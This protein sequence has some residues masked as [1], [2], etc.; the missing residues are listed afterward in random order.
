MNEQDPAR[1]PDAPDANAPSDTIDFGYER[2]PIGEKAGRVAEVFRSVAPRYDVM[3]DLMSLG[4]HRIL[5]RMTIEL[6]GV[7]EG[8]RVLDLAGG[9]GDLARLF[10]PRVG[11]RGRVILS[12]INAAMLEVGRDRM[13]DEGHANVDAV[14]ADAE[15]LPFADGTFDCV[16]IAFGLRNVTRKD[17]A[18]EEMRRVLAPGGRL[19]VLEFSKPRNPLLSRAYDAF[20]A[21]WPAMGRLVAGDADSYRYLNESIRMHP[22]QEALAEMMTSAGFD[23]VRFHDLLG[24]IVALH[25]GVAP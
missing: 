4:T 14:L 15:R 7:R 20:A 3:N 16:T 1:R 2:V 6:S 24:G 12:D 11:A 5:K 19:L 23:E 22:P 21:T 17:R 13:L 25:R 18:L 8:H 10:A 9:T